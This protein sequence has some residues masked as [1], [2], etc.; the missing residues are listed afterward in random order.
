MVTSPEHQPPSA[1]EK[2]AGQWIPPP[3]EPLEIRVVMSIFALLGILL[4]AKEFYPAP[5][6]AHRNVGFSFLLA[7]T[8]AGV[9]FRSQG[10][11]RSN[12]P[13]AA[14]AAVAFVGGLLSLYVGIVEPHRLISCFLNPLVLF[15]VQYLAAMVAPIP[16]LL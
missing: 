14:A 10:K 2:E 6:E 9:L 4:F 5:T 8:N 15:F 12:V 1:L 13:V 16:Q 3:L 11:W 7:F